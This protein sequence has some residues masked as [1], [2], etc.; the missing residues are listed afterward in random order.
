MPHGQ[1]F[2]V[3]EHSRRRR[4][5]NRWVGSLEDCNSEPGSKTSNCSQIPGSQLYVLPVTK[6]TTMEAEWRVLEDYRACEHGILRTSI[7]DDSRV[8]RKKNIMQIQDANIHGASVSTGRFLPG[9]TG[10]GVLFVK[11]M[12]VAKLTSN[13]AEPSF[14]NPNCVQVQRTPFV[15]R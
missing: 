5:R 13:Q 14:P 15:T 9:I 6:G 7:V 10:Q 4:D 3:P 8:A 12:A 11:Q 2:R 1:M